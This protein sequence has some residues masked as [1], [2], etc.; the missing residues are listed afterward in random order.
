MAGRPF[1]GNRRGG[2]RGD[3][4]S[5]RG[6]VQ[7]VPPPRAAGRTAGL[8]DVRDPA[9]DVLVGKGHRR[10]L[11]EVERVELVTRRMVLRLEEGVEI[12]ERR[13]DE[14]ALDL[15]EAHAQEDPPD[16]FDVGAQDVPLPRVDERGERLRVVPT[17]GDV[18]PSTG[19][20]EI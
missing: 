1:H 18:A 14:V 3:R 4:R 19:L 9:Y 20:Q 8:V 17:E 11:R 10:G 13:E 5:R 15:R 12:P 2:E 7:F 6:G 16:L